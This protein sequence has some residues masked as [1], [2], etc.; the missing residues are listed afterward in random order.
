MTLFSG[1]WLL[2]VYYQNAMHYNAYR[3]KSIECD[4]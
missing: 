1:S 4:V 2:V 3:G